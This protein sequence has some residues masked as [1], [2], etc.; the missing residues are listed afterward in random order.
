MIKT[1]IRRE[2]EIDAPAE[3]VWQLVGFEEG[4]RRW[5]GAPIHL[6]P[7]EGG[8]CEEWSSVQGAPR[9]QRGVVTVYDPPRRLGMTFYPDGGEVDSDGEW[10]PMT[11]ITISIQEQAGRSVVQVVH[12]AHSLVPVEAAAYG[13]APVVQEAIGPQMRLSRSPVRY[14]ARPRAGLATPDA[15]WQWTVRLAA[16]RSAIKGD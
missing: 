6:E 8:R 13:E 14:P 3:R 7:K 9:R 4:L 11:T 5:W 12:E 2:I 1:T 16:L 15:G 10:P